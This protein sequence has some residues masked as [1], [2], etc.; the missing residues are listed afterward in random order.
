MIPEE[1]TR[2]LQNGMGLEECLIKHETNLKVLF[3]KKPS[4]FEG[5]SQYIERRGKHYYIKKKIM[6]RT[7]YFGTYATLKDAR[8]VRGRLI[9]CDWKQNQVD[10][11]CRELGVE[12]IISKNERRYSDES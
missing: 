1:I 12:R 10:R 2:D 9:L 11:I 4:P 7:Y 8:R 3:K 6:N 5:M